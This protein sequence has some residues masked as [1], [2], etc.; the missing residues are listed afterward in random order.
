MNRLS[1]ARLLDFCVSQRGRFEAGAWMGF[2]AVR[3]EELA[4]VA[5]FLWLFDSSA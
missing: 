5:L 2:N 3:S 1:E 4:A